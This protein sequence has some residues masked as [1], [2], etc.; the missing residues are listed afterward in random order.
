MEAMANQSWA[1]LALFTTQ[2]DI[3]NLGFDERVHQPIDAVSQAATGSQLNLA[4]YH[5]YGSHLK[6]FDATGCLGETASSE[7][8][9]LGRLPDYDV[10]MPPPAT[11]PPVT[12]HQG[13]QQSD[14]GGSVPIPTPRS[15]IARRNSHTRGQRALIRQRKYQVRKLLGTR[16]DQCPAPVQKRNADNMGNNISTAME[17]LKK[18][19]V[20]LQDV[21]HQQQ[22]LANETLAEWAAT[23][24]R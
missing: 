1:D 13:P 15:A 9:L 18:L 7:Q 10:V 4:P 22:K 3:S 5:P 20:H 14:F 16:Q 21:T 12:P 6:R 23:K 17:G 24:A 11:P 19:E 2:Y 8:P